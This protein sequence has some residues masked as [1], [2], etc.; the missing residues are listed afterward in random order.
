MSQRL[1]EGPD[2]TLRECLG[3]ARM[4]E[5]EGDIGGALTVSTEMK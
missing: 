5:E 1:A 2:W 3:V 4:K